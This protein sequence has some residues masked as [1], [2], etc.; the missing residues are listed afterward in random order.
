MARQLFAVLWIFA[1]LASPSAFASPPADKTAD[2]TE[3]GYASYYAHYFEG[4]R[5][6]S[7][8]IF[9]NGLLMAAHPTLPFGTVA[10][11]TN[12]AHG[13]SVIVR[14]ADRG[15]APSIVRRGTIIDLSQA[16]AAQLKML[17]AGRVPVSV[18]VLE[19]GK[20]Y[21]GALQQ[22]VT[23]DPQ[24]L[25]LHLPDLEKILISDSD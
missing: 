23:F 24:P 12:L 8:D 20:G 14:I 9:R 25:R 7:G 15:P 11:V 16:A 1:A 4:R 17:A 18:K 21:V 6:A 22:A 2:K 3:T 13:Y 19:W 10:L 5:T